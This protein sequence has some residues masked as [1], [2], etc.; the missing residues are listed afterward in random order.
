MAEERITA[1]DAIPFPM[2]ACEIR[3]FLGMCDYMRRYIRHYDEI[4]K[5]LS[6]F[7]NSAVSEIDTL[8]TCASFEALKHAVQKHASLAS[9]K[10]DVQI[11]LQVDASVIR[12][13]G[14]IGNHY[15]D[16]DQHC[17]YYLLTFTEAESTWRT[18]EQEAFAILFCVF[19]CSVLYGDIRFC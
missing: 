9:L 11:F 3:R 16:E 14:T 5:P 19:F 15:P 18:I 6:G 4:Y 1:V 13:G 17:G 8:E 10:Y 2:N 12:V 7:V